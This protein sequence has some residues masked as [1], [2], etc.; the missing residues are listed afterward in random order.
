MQPERSCPRCGY[1]TTLPVAAACPVCNVPLV[2]QERTWLPSRRRAHRTALVPYVMGRV[3]DQFEA[4]VLDL[5]ILGARLEHT[6]TLRSGWRY[7][8]TLSI[9][10]ETLPLSLPV[11]VVWSRVQRSERGRGQAGPVYESGAEFRDLPPETKQELAAFLDRRRN[12]RPAPIV[13]MVA[14]PRD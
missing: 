12:A 4:T 3:D 13:G 1:A 8:L 5:S 11:R 6:E 9:S 10:E 7:V 2:L 14:S